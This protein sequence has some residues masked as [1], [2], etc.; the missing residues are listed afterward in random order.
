MCVFLPNAT[1]KILSSLECQL[2]TSPIH[3]NNIPKGVGNKGVLIKKNGRI[4]NKTNP[5]LYIYMYYN[6]YVT[7]MLNKNKLDYIDSID[8]HNCQQIPSVSRNRSA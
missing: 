5:T 1:N 8:I 3:A 6:V 7:T 2:V 4:A